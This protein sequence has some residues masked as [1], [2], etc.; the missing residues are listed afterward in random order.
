MKSDIRS[1][2]SDTV[3]NMAWWSW[4]ETCDKCGSHIHGHEVETLT[5]S[6]TEEKD[7][8]ICCLRNFLDSK[9]SKNN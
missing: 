7:Y 8:C 3:R 5:K 4:I 6:N 1:R 2:N 9:H